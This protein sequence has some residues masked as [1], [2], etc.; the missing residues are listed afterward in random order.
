MKDLYELQ[1]CILSRNASGGILGLDLPFPL[2]QYLESLR[3]FWGCNVIYRDLMSR[4]PLVDNRGSADPYYA[5]REWVKI[6][7]LSYLVELRAPYQRLAISTSPG[8]ESLK[9]ATLL[10]MRSFPIW[11]EVFLFGVVSDPTSTSQGYRQTHP[12]CE[13]S[14][15]DSDSSG[16]ESS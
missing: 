12:W 9:Q 2:S 11:I 13:G 6:F 16:T 1:E 10:V 5:I 15:E 8:E 14:W 4:S 7:W 3:W